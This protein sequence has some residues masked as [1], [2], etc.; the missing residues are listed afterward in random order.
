MNS[1]TLSEHSCAD[2]CTD[3]KN[4]GEQCGHCLIQHVEKQELSLGVAPDSAY[5]KEALKQIQ[6]NL[7]SAV[8]GINQALKIINDNPDDFSWFSIKQQYYFDSKTRDDLISIDELRDAC[9]GYF[10]EFFGGIRAIQYILDEAPKGTTHFDRYFEKINFTEKTLSLWVDGAWALQE[11]RML[12]FNRAIST[13]VSLDDLRNALDHYKPVIIPTF[14]DSG[15]QNF[16]YLQLTQ[17]TIAQIEFFNTQKYV[18][19]QE[20]DQ[21]EADVFDNQADG[22]YLLWLSLTK[23]CRTNADNERIQALVGAKA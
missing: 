3:F 21:R 14:D 18:A 23:D 2:K 13:S 8:G 12:G 1:I 16:S 22:V 15:V 5:T 9:H 11:L 19:A 6:Q 4:K 7:L 20:D 17:A 10:I